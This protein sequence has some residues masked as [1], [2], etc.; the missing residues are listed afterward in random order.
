MVEVAYHKIE[1]PL[2]ISVD[3]AKSPLDLS[4]QLV[5]LQRSVKVPV[6]I[7]RIKVGNTL[8][9]MPRQRSPPSAKARYLKLN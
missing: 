2:I 6:K 4:A 9:A 7:E 1:G 3:D 8:I 5:D